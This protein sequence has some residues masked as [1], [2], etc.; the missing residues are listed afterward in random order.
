MGRT[1][2][3]KCFRDGGRCSGKRGFVSERC[4]VHRDTFSGKVLSACRT[5]RY[6]VSFRQESV[7]EPGMAD[8]GPVESSLMFTIKAGIEHSNRSSW[9]FVCAQVFAVLE[10]KAAR[11]V[12]PGQRE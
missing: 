5:N 12:L 2:L 4:S 8:P 6:R 1:V 9:C 3:A 11:S 10:G 7:R